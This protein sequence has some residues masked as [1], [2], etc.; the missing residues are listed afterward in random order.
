MFPLPFETRLADAIDAA[1]YPHLYSADERE[2]AR[3]LLLRFGISGTGYRH[4]EARADAD[5]L[6]AY[7]ETNP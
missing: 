1:H 7:G 4:R 6:K 5:S 3:K 2:D